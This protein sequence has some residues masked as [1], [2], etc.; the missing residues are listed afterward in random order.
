MRDATDHSD[1]PYWAAIMASKPSTFQ[2]T[3]RP[4]FGGRHSRSGSRKDVPILG[5]WS[6][7]RRRECTRRARCPTFLTQ[8]NRG[9]GTFNEQQ[10]A[11]C[12]HYEPITWMA[13]L[14]LAGRRHFGEISVKILTMVPQHSQHDSQGPSQTNR[15][16]SA[17]RRRSRPLSLQDPEGRRVRIGRGTP[18]GAAEGGRWSQW[19]G[20]ETR[21]FQHRPAVKFRALE[22]VLSAS[23]CK[24]EVRVRPGSDRS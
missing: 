2:P 14:F 3:G 17:E 9:I 12:P 13:S 18:G 8:E 1:A 15:W 23:R 6:I 4:D 21:G 24:E 19:L 7:P 10:S 5:G 11:A 22:P 20:N 16:V